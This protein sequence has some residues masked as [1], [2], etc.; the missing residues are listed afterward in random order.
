[1]STAC[2]RLTSPQLPDVG[3]FTA[4]R[5]LLYAIEWWVFGGFVVLIWWRW[6]GEQLAPDPDEVA[7]ED[8]DQ[9]DTVTA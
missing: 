3:R 2:R 9:P 5:N 7:E 6:L 1:M 4:L 8:E